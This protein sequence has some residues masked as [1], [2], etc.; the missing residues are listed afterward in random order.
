MLKH[1]FIY[2]LFFIVVFS[3]SPYA[4]FSKT[5]VVAQ[6]SNIS[7]LKAGVALAK[8]GDTILVKK[9]VYVS[10]NTIIDKQLT[11]LGKDYPVLDAQ[12][13]EEVLTVKADHVKIDGF[14]IRN[15]K[16]GDLRDFAG[17]RVFRSKYIVI[18]NNRF[19][20]NFFAIYISDA[21]HVQINNNKLKGTFTY[22]KSG[23]GIHV[24]QS[25]SIDVRNNH[26]TGQRDGVYFEFVQRSKVYNNISENNMRY[27]LHFMFSNDNS[28]LRNTFKN[29]QAG[30]AVMYSKR[31]KMLQNDF[32]EN[33]GSSIY[34]LLLK[35]IVDSH[36][37]QNTFYKNTSAIFMES[38]NRNT[39]KR[40]IFSNNGWAVR[41][42]SNC[43][44]NN[45]F[46]NNF[47]ANSFDVTTNGELL[48]NKFYNNYWDKYEGYD[49]NKDGV[50]D[51]PYRPISLYAQIIERVP[52]SVILMRSF[53]VNL[54]DKVERSI[55]SITPL[56][57][58]DDSPQM[59]PWKI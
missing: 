34:G 27:G 50:G 33:W 6:G 41:V 56:S 57:V 10:H 28:Y 59:K 21:H 31:I 9:G 15:S 38:C 20:D 25:D 2:L 45:F 14:V 29:N 17:L 58:K 22:R 39:I 11:I 5:I 53:I 24:W 16:V 4:G 51:V 48:E 43:Q 55:P 8:N 3:I 54:L 40:N 13:K 18:S 52:Q 37:E 32:S 7:S 12:F 44:D 19:V 49:L 47:K 23:N 30:V 26:I 46:K 36:I 42:L 35:E 1:K